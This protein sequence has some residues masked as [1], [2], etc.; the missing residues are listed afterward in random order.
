MVIGSFGMETAF[1]RYIT[2]FNKTKFSSVFSSAFL[3]LMINSLII[4]FLGCLF[5]KPIAGIIGYAHEPNY[6]LYFAFIIGV[7]LMCVIPFA[8]LRQQ[9]KAFKF[10]VVKTINI[11]INIFAIY[12]FCFCCP[13]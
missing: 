1:F 2:Q 11:L 5:Y 8:L 12:F 9:N 6:I 7:D 13:T 10:A 3:F 4:I